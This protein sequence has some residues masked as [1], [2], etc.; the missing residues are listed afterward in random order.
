[1]GRAHGLSRSKSLYYAVGSYDLLGVVDPQHLRRAYDVLANSSDALRTVLR[2]IDEVPMQV[3]LDRSP[4][5][6]D[7]VD[8]SAITG[9]GLCI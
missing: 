3:V 8:L 4:S 9:A 1:M 2:T 7:Y 6:L 5:V